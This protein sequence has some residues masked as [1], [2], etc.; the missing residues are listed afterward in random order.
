MKASCSFPYEGCKCFERMGND[1]W[2]LPAGRCLYEEKG[3]MPPD[4]GLKAQVRPISEC[5]SATTVLKETWFPHLL[6]EKEKAQI[7][8]V[9]TAAALAKTN[10]VK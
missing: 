2:F 6:T 4:Q 1:F 9:R 8:P 7:G 3:S 10:R 5:F